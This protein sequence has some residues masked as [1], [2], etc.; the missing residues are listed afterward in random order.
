M[1]TCSGCDKLR[2]YSLSAYLTHINLCIA[3]ICSYIP[4]MA[5]LEVDPGNMVRIAVF[6][7][8]VPRHI[9]GSGVT[10]R[11]IVLGICESSDIV[12]QWSDVC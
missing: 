8:K 11:L 6:V 4:L 2:R 7:V 9:A 5:G 10:I 12:L 3:L 1:I